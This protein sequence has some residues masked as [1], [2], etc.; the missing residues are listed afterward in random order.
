MHYIS[1]PFL[2]LLLIILLFICI[3]GISIVGIL[4]QTN[5][6][7]DVSLIKQFC[8]KNISKEFEVQLL[9]SDA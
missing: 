6:C 3:P 2:L 4:L 5:E 8:H 9:V 7:A 1:L